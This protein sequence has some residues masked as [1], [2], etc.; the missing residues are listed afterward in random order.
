MPFAVGISGTRAQRKDKLIKLYNSLP[1]DVGRYMLNEA[2][3]DG[4]VTQSTIN[5]IIRQ[6]QLQKLYK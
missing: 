1:P 4:K 6:S 3:E 2:K 5:E